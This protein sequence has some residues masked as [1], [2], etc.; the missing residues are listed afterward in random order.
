[1]Q[2]S[3]GATIAQASKSVM[4]RTEHRV[5][6]IGLLLVSWGT[7]WEKSL[8]VALTPTVTSVFQSNNIS[9]VLTTV[10]SILQTALQPMYSKLSDMTGRAQAFTISI[11]FFVLS[12]VIMACAHDYNTLIGGQ[13]VYAFGFS[14][15][16]ILG[17]ILIGDMTDIVDRSMFLALYN[18]PTIINLFVPSAVAQKIIDS[19][20]W[21][22]GYGHITLVM[23]ITSAPLMFILWHT[24]YKAQKAGLIT[25]KKSPLAHLSFWHQCQWIMQQVDM[26]GSVLLMTAMFL[27]LLPLNLYTKW[28]GWTSATTLGLIVAG[29][30]ACVLFMIWEWKLAPKPIIPLNHWESKNPIWAVLTIFLVYIINNMMDFQYFLTYLQVTRRVTSQT[31]TYLERGFNVT[32]VCLPLLIGYLMKRTRQWRPFVWIGVSAA[33]LGPGLMIKARNSHSPDVFIVISQV[34]Y[35]VACAFCNYPLLVGIQGSVPPNDV[36]IAIT[37]FEVGASVAGSVGTTIANAAWNA[38]MPGLFVKYVHG[39]YEYTKIVSSISYAL[40]LPEDQYQG[41]VLAYDDAMRLLCI[42][43]T[44]VGALGFLASI[45]LKG[46]MLYEQEDKEEGIIEGTDISLDK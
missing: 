7:T 34:V 32:Y 42:I 33:V 46:Y 35:G 2:L 45:P 28:G 1:M 16:Y 14:G 24:Q 12:F 19:G 8:V 39:N 43:A 31:A 38:I 41:V 36:A 10:L 22:W 30:I 27:V 11:V 20:Q 15:T 17:P 40:A 44:C 29:S 5:M 13:V 26:I 18:F 3:K 21:R 4:T 25:V 37:L 9:G 6:L 23:T